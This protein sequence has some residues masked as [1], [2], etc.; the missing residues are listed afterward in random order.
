MP[1]QE[2]SSL[3]PSGEGLSSPP[4]LLW[5]LFQEAP[6][7]GPRLSTAPSSLHPVCLI[8]PNT[9]LPATPVP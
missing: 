2:W 1:S 3:P 9:V 8:T 6:L 4:Q 7:T 5:P